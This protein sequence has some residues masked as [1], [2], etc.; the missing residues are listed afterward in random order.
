[1]NKK[2][3]KFFLSVVI[4]FLALFFFSCKSDIPQSLKIMTYNIHRGQDA[5]NNDRLME[6][7][8]FIK[9]SGAD[10]VGLEEVDSV[11]YR[12]G[13]VDQARILAEY[14]G[15]YYTFVRHFAFQGGA[16][17]QALLSK[18]PITEV[19]NN[20]LPV[21]TDIPGQTTAFLTA[22]INVSDKKSFLTGVAHLDYRNAESRVKQAEI[23]NDI[24]TDS[25]IPG[26]LLGD[27]NAEPDTWEILI[28]KEKFQD[29]HPDDLLT[30]PDGMPV[31]KIDYI[32]VD[33]SEKI[34]VTEHKV[35]DV[36]FSDH[37]PVLA[38][39]KHYY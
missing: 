8:V 27:M 30:F 16:Y 31:K 5:D 37:L 22:R 2:V 34:E 35:I 23:I 33:K 21:V 15:M 29:T 1:M 36:S 17:G 10:I 14:S 28:F 4:L 9:E 3:S 39:I 11:C 25:D 38:T 18:Y 20:R 32:F 12:S 13:Q 26:I 19:K 7:A 6:M 24:Y